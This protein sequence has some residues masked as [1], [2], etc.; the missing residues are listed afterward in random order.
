MNSESLALI[1]AVLLASTLFS[2]APIQT[3]KKTA[4]SASA[5]GTFDVKVTPQPAAESDDPSFT[6]FTVE[7]QFH[8]DMEGTSKV[9]MLAAGTAIKDSGGYVALEKV[10]ATLAGRKGT[11]VLQHMGSM[12]GGAFNLNIAVVPDSGTD[13]LRGISGKFSIDIKD[14]KHFY[15]F[16]YSLPASH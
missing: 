5:N 7:K 11:F 16:D 10:T 12:K 2:P 3:N 13:Q 8:G 6:R 1:A 14:G 9:Q 15:A 4:V